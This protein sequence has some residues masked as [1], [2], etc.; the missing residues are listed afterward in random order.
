MKLLPPA[1]SPDR[2]RLMWLAVLLA[3]G[4]TVWWWQ[5]PPAETAG[6][7]SNPTTAERTTG[8]A[9]LPMPEA[10]RLTN[11]EDVPVMGDAERNPFGFG[12]RPTPPPPPML[13]PA[14]APTMPVIPPP[15]PV[16][17]G[18]PP[19]PLK[20]AGMTVPVAGGRTL[21]TLKDPAT[22]AVHLAF[23]GD[24][25]D[26]RYRVVKVGERSVVLSYVDGTG[27]RTIPLGG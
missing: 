5:R 8:A 16:P 12:V 20:L 17:Q 2:R 18:P 24:V 27:L 15:A 6:T 3:G 22:N 13:R 11:L 21:V 14:V 9:P 4:V 10:V 23:E 7:S 26:G 1:G 19:I 25:V